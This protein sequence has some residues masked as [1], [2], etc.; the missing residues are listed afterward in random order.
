MVTEGQDRPS[1]D[2]P[3]DLIPLRYQRSPQLSNDFMRW[4][5]YTIT[6]QQNQNK[7]KND[8]SSDNSFNSGPPPINVRR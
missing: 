5:N 8:S 3:Q 6:Q 4:V 7:S 1:K 2:I